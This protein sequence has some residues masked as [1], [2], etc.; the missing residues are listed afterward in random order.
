[1]DFVELYKELEALERRVIVKN[2][3]IQQVNLETDGGTCQHEEQLEEVGSVL[4]A[5][6]T[7]LNLSEEIN[8]RQLNEETA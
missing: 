1:M 4:V 3:N 2:H 5:E 6:L 7:G 8:E